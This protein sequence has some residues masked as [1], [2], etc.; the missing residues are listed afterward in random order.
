MV[1]DLRADLGAG[2]VPFVA[3]KLGE[4]LKRQDKDG[5]PSHW[6][7][8]N[9]LIGALPQSVANTAS[10]DSTGLKHKGDG[11]HFDTPSLRE[12]GQRYA[13]AMKRLQAGKAR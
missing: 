8:V 3:G 1:K 10:V 11:V 4:F 12:F 9:E 6:P 13:E 5:R 7:L 2:D